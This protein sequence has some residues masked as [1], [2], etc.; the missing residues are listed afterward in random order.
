MNSEQLITEAGKAIEE[1]LHN[2]NVGCWL[3]ISNG[4]VK[5][6][7]KLKADDCNALELYVS[8]W[9]MEHGLSTRQWNNT[10]TAL[11]NLYN[12]EVACQAHQKH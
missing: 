8:G 10:G 7:A 9:Q 11:L 3:S 2:H 6:K 12:K 4:H 1:W 5:C